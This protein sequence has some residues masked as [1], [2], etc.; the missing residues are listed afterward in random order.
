MRWALTQAWGKVPKSAG[1]RNLRAAK[2]ANVI[3]QKL[4]AAW[5]RVAGNNINFVI[6]TTATLVNT[7]MGSI[8]HA[9]SAVVTFGVKEMCANASAV[10][11]AIAVTATL[12][13]LWRRFRIANHGAILR[14]ILLNP[15]DKERPKRFKH[16]TA[17]RQ[18]KYRQHPPRTICSEPPAAGRQGEEP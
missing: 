8:G 9:I 3:I 18:P 11:I 1:R 5:I 14:F 15:T 12:C 4:C 6:M 10:E 7:Q 13:Y 17:Q 16:R 2:R